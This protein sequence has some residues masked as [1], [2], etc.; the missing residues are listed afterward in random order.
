MD[1]Y[2]V[3]KFQE[4]RAQRLLGKLPK[5]DRCGDTLQDGYLW[6]I[7]GLCL[8]DDC[9]CQMYRFSTEGDAV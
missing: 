9:A 8:C 4:K 3:W 5:C 7:D 2:D 1:A 6:R